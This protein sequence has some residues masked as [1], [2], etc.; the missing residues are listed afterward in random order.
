MMLWDEWTTGKRRSI[1]LVGRCWWEKSKKNKKKK[2]T[3]RKKTFSR[4]IYIHLFVLF[5]FSFSQCLISRRFSSQPFKK[6]TTRKRRRLHLSPPLFF[7]C[8]FFC[9]SF[10]ENNIIATTNQRSSST[11]SWLC[12]RISFTNWNMFDRLFTVHPLRFFSIWL[13]RGTR[14]LRKMQRKF[15]ILHFVQVCC[16]FVY[17]SSRYSDTP[18]KQKGGHIVTRIASML[19]ANNSHFPFASLAKKPQ[20]FATDTINKKK[21]QK[22]RRQQTLIRW[23]MTEDDYDDHRYW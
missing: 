9:F 8:F 13:R 10:K 6:L 23:E 21:M 19:S 15:I 20:R 16:I 3:W 22:Q 17:R 14:F 5:S 18:T 1:H 11:S 7:F 12:F 2:T 4:Y